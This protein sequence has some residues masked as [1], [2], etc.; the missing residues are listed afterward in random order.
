MSSAASFCFGPCKLFVGGI[1]AQTTTEVLH[2]HFSQYGRLVDT[3]VMV[4]NGRPRGFGFVTYDAPGPALTALAE[5]QW[6]DGRLVDV[7]LAVPGEDAQERSPNKIFVGGLPQDVDTKTLKAYFSAYGFVADA[8]VMVDRQTNRSRGFGFVRFA[9]GAQGSVASEAVLM[10]FPSHR[11]AGKWV[12]VKRATPAAA[13]QEASAGFA[14]FG[15]FTDTSGQFSPPV[16]PTAATNAALVAGVAT[17]MR[18][19]AL[20]RR[21]KQRSHRIS[22]GGA[23]ETSRLSGTGDDLSG[24][25]DWGPCTLKPS[26]GHQGGAAEVAVPSPF[27]LPE[28]MASPRLVEPLAC[29]SE[30]GLS[31]DFPSGFGASPMKVSTWLLA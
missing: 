2:A 7:K 10:D 23:S 27:P 8:V 26:S 16:S 19:H 15:S 17:P 1:S 9:N 18:N 22:N 30:L 28:P 20:G 6:I 21:G 25:D 24:S 11:L 3:V 14:G 31:K 13:L 4:K 5:P 12:E 29:C